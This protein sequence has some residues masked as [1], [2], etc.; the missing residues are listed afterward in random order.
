M[1]AH[2][3]LATFFPCEKCAEKSTSGSA[4]KNDLDTGSFLLCCGAVTRLHMA[5]YEHIP[6]KINQII[7]LLLEK[8]KERKKEK[9]SYPHCL[10]VVLCPVPV[11]AGRSRAAPLTS[12]SGLRR[13][14]RVFVKGP[15]LRWPGRIRSSRPASTPVAQIYMREKTHRHT[16][17]LASGAAFIV[18]Q[19]R[20]FISRYIQWFP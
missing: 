18:P 11:Q 13:I 19:H 9:V 3:W 20:S 12:C 15:Q 2:A 1:C 14:T 5:G 4:S 6:L 10:Q 7:F 16:P 8:K 17:Y